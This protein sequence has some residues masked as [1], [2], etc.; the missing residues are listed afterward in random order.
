MVFRQ[1]FAALIYVIAAALAFIM[2]SGFIAVALVVLLIG[3][4]Y[5]R[6]RLRRSVNQFKDAFYRS[7]SMSSAPAQ[8]PHVL[9]GEFQVIEPIEGVLPEGT[10]KPKS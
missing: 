7:S 5:W 2:F 1:I 4:V 10:E 9:E 3:S 8:D 6:W